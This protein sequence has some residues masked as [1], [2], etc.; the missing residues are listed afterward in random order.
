[1]L[2]VDVDHVGAAADAQRFGLKVRSVTRL[3]LVQQLRVLQRHTA[4]L[5]DG[6]HRPTLFSGVMNHP[7]I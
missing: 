1:M 5:V 3:Q 4:W 2:Q 6:Y 7:Y